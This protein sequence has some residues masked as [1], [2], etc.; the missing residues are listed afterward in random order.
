MLTATA[1]P[2]GNLG[3]QGLGQPELRIGFRQPDQTTIR[4][5][6]VDVEAGFQVTGRGDERNR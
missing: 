3:R 4:G 6:V 5:Q 2:V 1:A